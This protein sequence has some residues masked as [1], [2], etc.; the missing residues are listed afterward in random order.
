MA[1][2]EPLL[3][4]FAEVRL[5]ARFRRRVSVADVLQETNLAVHEHRADFE[6]HGPYSFRNWLL[7][8]A[9]RKIGEVI[10]RHGAAGRRSVGREVTADARPAT[11]ELPG[12]SSTP[13]QVAIAHELGELARRALT[14]L[15]ESSR[16]VLRLVRE[17]HLSLAQ[18]AER[19]GRSYEATKKLYAR[20]LAR[21]VREFE[22]LRGETRGR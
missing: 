5:P 16:E 1:R 20:A 19:A 2:H 6:A 14:T 12:G 4:R 7:R 9:E 13:S 3:R 10:R 18:A 8:I 21:F 15:P 11:G 22:R 17:E